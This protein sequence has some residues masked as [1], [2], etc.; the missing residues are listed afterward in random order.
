VR[1]D[2]VTIFPDLVRAVLGHSI[3]KR[4]QDAGLV[5]VQA[6]DLR[7]FTTDKHRSVDDTPYGGGAGMLMRPAP[8]FDAVASL[9]LAPGD[10]VILLTPQGTVFNQALARELSERPRMTLLCGHYEGFDERVRTH[11]ATHEISIGD[12]VLTGGELPALTVIDA[13]VRLLPGV[14]GSHESAAADSHA[15]GLLEYP[16]YTRPPEY[17]GWRVPDVLLSGHHAEIAKWRRK[18]QFRRTQSRRPDLWAAFAPSKS[19]LKLLDQ[20]SLEEAP[21]VQLTEDHTAPFAG[22]ANEEIQQNASADSSD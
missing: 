19:D 2:V 16:H 11:L 15:D 22:Q 8:L 10:P 13:V 4:A 5:T 3:M 9:D 1:I 12:Y 17:R 6:H 7:D 14:L 18:E 20:M 21:L